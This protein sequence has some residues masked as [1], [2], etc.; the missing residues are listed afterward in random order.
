MVTLKN[1]IYRG[2]AFESWIKFSN[3]ATDTKQLEIMKSWHKLNQ[4]IIIKFLL[5]CPLGT[6]KTF[7]A[8]DRTCKP[9]PANSI[10]KDVGS[11]T[12]S[13]CFCKPGFK[14]YPHLGMPCKRK[15]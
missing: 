4:I 14:G 5:E 6:Y 13:A 2:T 12:I 11:N 7:T 8:P 3:S 10:T 1:K 9:C 15:N